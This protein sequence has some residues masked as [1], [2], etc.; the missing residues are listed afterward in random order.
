MLGSSRVLTRGGFGCYTAAIVHHDAC[1]RR[2]KGV[3]Q[4]SK[5]VR[6]PIL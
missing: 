4:F 5:G 6:L 3:N 2:A 1:E